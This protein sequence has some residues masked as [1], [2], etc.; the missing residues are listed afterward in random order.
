MV[1]K[2]SI[3]ATGGIKE[4]LK[5]TGG[6]GL[7]NFGGVMQRLMAQKPGAMNREFLDFINQ[8][9]DKTR[10][11]YMTIKD[12]QPVLTKQ[13]KA[14]K[15]AFD[16]AVIGEYQLTQSQTID[17]TKA[18]WNAFMK[19]KAAGVSAAQAIEMVADAELAVAIN[20]KDIDSKELRRMATDAKAAS[21]ALKELQQDLDM[22]T[23]EGQFKIFKESYGEAVDYFDAQEA[24][25]RQER[26]GSSVFKG[27]TT[28]I[29]TQT[30][31]IEDATETINGY[32]N[33][34][35][36]LQRKLET[37]ESFGTRVIDQLNSKIETAQRDL[38]I[39]AV[40]GSRVI[41]G[42][43]A[44][45]DAL[46]R[47]AEI[48]FDR[49]L[50]NLS[51]E[52]D[53]LSNTLGLIDKQEEKINKKYELQEQ[54][55]SKIA[56]LNSEIA[57]QQKQRLT[58]ADA[59]SQGDIA[60]AAA[61]AQDMRAT[62]A[63]AASRRSSGTLA[64]AREA[65]I[66][67]VSVAGISRVQIEERQ[68]QI[69]QQTF[70]LQQQR[71]IVEANIQRIQDQ[72]FAKEQLRLPITAQ[73]QSLQDQIYA[74]EQLR[75][76][77][78][79][80]IQVLQDK[81]YQTQVN[82]LDP[83]QK[84][85][86]K[87]TKAREQYEKQTDALIKTITYQGQT[88][89]Q[90]VIINTELTAVESKLKAVEAETSKSARNTA[91]ILASWQALKSKT[92]TLTEN[93]NRIITTTNIVNTV[94]TSSG[95]SGSTSSS[96]SSG[97]KSG[98]TNSTGSFSKFGMYG[99]KVLPMARG[100]V[101]PEYFANGG[102]MGS[103]SVPTMLTPGEFVMNRAATKQFG[104][105]LND[106]NNSKFP[107]MIKD[108][109]PAVYSSNNSSLITPTITSVATTVSDSS[110][111][112]YNYNIGITVPQSNASSN[113]IARAVMGQIKYIDSQRIRGQK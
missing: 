92:I 78:I 83:A 30:Q 67:G 31:K 25:I 21:K 89:D 5:Q 77:I 98:N 41:D 36:V 32:Q 27:F 113:D 73:I 66:V 12:G 82:S 62:A 46:N 1:R 53:I 102:R 51:D 52:S 45:V 9:D 110:T 97:S 112:M 104:P 100:G 33:S 13:G 23:R 63:E 70:A 37:D 65:E 106:I 2:A 35:D 81:I 58:L 10:K 103:D 14:L 29:E 80:Q 54:A 11:T 57:A 22:E 44:Q 74:K 4:L 96:G 40:Y 109:S 101:V 47:T 3:N 60:A 69:G 34:I 99:G 38:E 7:T 86:D 91:A 105:M 15:E 20:G 6:K 88:K 17:S 71:Q 85:L 87:A 48:E 90:W 111:T 64:A 107:S 19:L 49:P 84:A 16:E 18:Q 43:N 79:N 56:E 28:E 95:S 68:F 72:I 59:L 61:A 94:Y 8:M 39:N 75:L 50:A 42:L 55:L 108:M 93:V 76:P 26:E 24:L